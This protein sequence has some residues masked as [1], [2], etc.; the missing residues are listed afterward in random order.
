MMDANEIFFF[1]KIPEALPLYE[2]IRDVICSEFEYVTI[3]VQKT[4]ITFSNKHGFAFVSYRKIKGHSG[5][6]II[7]TL[8]LN[9]R[10]E[11]PRVLVATE[12]Y[13]GRWTH[14][15]IIQSEGEV[16]AELKEWIAEAYFF[17]MMK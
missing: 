12:P 14:H 9:R 2:A 7:F 5:V 1:N 13:P 3:K 11:H 17:A 4:Q 15:I 10:L 8:G 6:Y 16:D